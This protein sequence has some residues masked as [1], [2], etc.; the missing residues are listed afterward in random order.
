MV[1]QKGVISRRLYECFKLYAFTLQNWIKFE[2]QFLTFLC[3]N[4]SKVYTAGKLCTVRFRY[5]TTIFNFTDMFLQSSA[6]FDANV[7]E[8][9][10]YIQIFASSVKFA[11]KKV[12]VSAVIS[13]VTNLR[14]NFGAKFQSYA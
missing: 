7:T 10:N 9:A 4:Y 5:E 3:E 12:E 6:F 8:D 2:F 14:L 1:S 13:W 11:L